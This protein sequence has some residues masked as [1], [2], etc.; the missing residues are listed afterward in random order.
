MAGPRQ[1]VFDLATRPALGRADF[2]V[3]PANR[4]ALAQVDTWPAWPGGRLAIAGPAGAGKTHLAHVWAARSGARLLPAAALA[5]LDIGAL[6]EGAALVVEDVDRLPE[7]PAAQA[8]AAEEA[9]FH[10]ANRLAAAGALM[11]SGREPPAR[12]A[13]RLPDL[14]SRLRASP[15]A[16]L[17]A[18]DDALLAAVL[19]KLFGDRQIVVEVDLVQY[20][21]TRMDRSFEAAEALVAELDRAALAR[22]RPVTRVLA[23]EIL[24]GAE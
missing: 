3:S 21:L 23:A 7:L 14:A 12:W 8:G 4:L 15:V 18:P 11:V 22:R 2:F 1:L 19:L 24:R 5:A 10:V 16:R 9:L 17:E 13:I 20:L 6:P